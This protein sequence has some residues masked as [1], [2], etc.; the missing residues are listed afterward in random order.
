MASQKQKIADALTT[1]DLWKL[2]RRRVPPIVSE[3][4]RGGADAETT[5]RGNVRAFQQSLTTAHGA[6]KFPCLLYTS[7]A[8]DE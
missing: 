5:L 1:A 4:F 2:M 7:D 3:Y 8:A 6:L